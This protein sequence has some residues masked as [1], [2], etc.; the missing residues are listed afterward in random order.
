MQYQKDVITPLIS[1]THFLIMQL[2][3]PK[4]LLW[5]HRSTA[6]IWYM[7]DVITE[8]ISKTT[9][10][11]RQYKKDVITELIS[12]IHFLA[13]ATQNMYKKI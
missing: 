2:A 5:V 11:P 7:K 10:L 12:E 9:F 13:H 6:I 8:L 3:V 1:E 4:V